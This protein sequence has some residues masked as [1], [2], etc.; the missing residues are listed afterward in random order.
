MTTPSR[1]VIFI[2]GLWLHASSWLPWLEKFRLAGYD[3]SAPDWP[4]DSETV[5]ASRA[6]PDG[7]AGRGV[8]EVVE[9]YTDTAGATD[10]VFGVARQSGWYAIHLDCRWTCSA[11]AICWATGSRPGSATWGCP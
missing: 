9:H 10:H 5:E 3:P 1:P 2:H 8:E 4:G 6:N 11:S 7:I